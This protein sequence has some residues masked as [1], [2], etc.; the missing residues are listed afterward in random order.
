MIEKA[1]LT[2]EMLLCCAQRRGATSAAGEP[3]IPQSA[4][5]PDAGGHRRTVQKHRGEF[6]FDLLLPSQAPPNTSFIVKP[7]IQLLHYTSNLKKKP[8]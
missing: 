5:Q 7:S 6:L 2:D 8:L 1:G 4:D 3:E